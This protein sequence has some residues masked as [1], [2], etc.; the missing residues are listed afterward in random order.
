V[1]YPAGYS[2]VR[3]KSL[4]T[5]GLTPLVV[6]RSNT[7]NQLVQNISSTNMSTS[8]MSDSIPKTQNGS[9]SPLPVPEEI[10]TNFSP[11]LVSDTTFNPIL[12]PLVEASTF[13]TSDMMSLSPDFGGAFDFTATNLTGPS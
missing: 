12:S 6:P 9:L 10:S 7:P 8:G 4:P 3:S 5:N 11:T 2:G 13:S 1:D